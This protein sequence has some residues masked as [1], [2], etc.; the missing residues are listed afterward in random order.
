MKILKKEKYKTKISFSGPPADL[1][2]Q[3]VGEKMNSQ[4]RGVTAAVRLFTIRP[5]T[6][7]YNI[8]FKFNEYYMGFGYALALYT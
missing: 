8:Y 6:N 7:R 2:M 1:C 3:T 5:P 4:Q